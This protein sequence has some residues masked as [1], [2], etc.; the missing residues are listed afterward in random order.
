MQGSIWAALEERLGEG[1]SQIPAAQWPVLM[2]IAVVL[3]GRLL[4]AGAGGA[5]AAPVLG[6]RPC[7]S[8]PLPG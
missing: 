4:L 1:G 6:I 3:V 7:S 2:A 8:W 5:F